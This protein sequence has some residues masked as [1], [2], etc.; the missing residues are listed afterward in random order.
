MKR[1][2]K[3]LT[4]SIELKNYSPK[5]YYKKEFKKLAEGFRNNK[6]IR[7]NIASTL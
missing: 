4:N 1:K 6:K 2:K 7:R 3:W 5:E